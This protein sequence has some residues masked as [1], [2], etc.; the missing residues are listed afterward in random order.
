MNT[1][2]SMRTLY[3]VIALS[4]LGFFSTPQLIAQSHAAATLVT[5]AHLLNTRTGN[6][7]SPAAVL[8][9]GNKISKVGCPAEVQPD[10]PPGVE[11]ID[12]GGATLLPGMI[13][14]HTHLLLDVV[15]PAEAE[16][17]RRPN[18]LF[19]PGLLLAISMSPG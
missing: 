16:I 4:F 11:T 14:S 3:G 6:L 17:S 19:I 1:K 9:Q 8:I 18:G 10:A 7:L 13:D 5:A 15:V 2:H 12:L